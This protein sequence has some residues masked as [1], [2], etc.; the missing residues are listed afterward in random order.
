MEKTKVEAAGRSEREVAAR[1][2]TFL[3]KIIMFKY[4]QMGSLSIDITETKLKKRN[5]SSTTPKKLNMHGCTT[6]YSLV[7]VGNPARLVN[8]NK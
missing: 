2:K 8:L 1:E 6:L 5:I 3:E 4:R 7:Q